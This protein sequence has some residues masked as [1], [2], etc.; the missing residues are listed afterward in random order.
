[1]KKLLTLVT[2]MLL[3]GSLAFA[4]TTG[5]S[6]DKTTT[7]SKTDSGKT[8]KKSGKKG[9]KGGKK[10]KKSSSDTTAAPK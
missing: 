2:T 9:H 8:G 1:M 4:Q 6:S 3:A 5:G 10:T 7:P